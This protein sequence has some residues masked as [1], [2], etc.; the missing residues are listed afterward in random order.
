MYIALGETL[1]RT[2]LPKFEIKTR[3]QHESGQVDNSLSFSRL[4]VMRS[5]HPWEVQKDLIAVGADLGRLMRDV[6][7]KRQQRVPGRFG[8]ECL[9]A[10]W[11][12]RS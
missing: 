4:R 8:I 9:E 3:L 1:Y 11:T 5:K 10:Q 2:Q 6:D 7:E 12:V